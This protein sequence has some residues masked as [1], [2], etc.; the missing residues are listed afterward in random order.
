MGE[1]LMARNCTVCDSAGRDAID[2][3]LVAGRSMRSIAQRHG[4]GEYAVA[5]HRD[6]HLSAALVATVRN[7]EGRRARTLLSRVEGI[8]SEAESI[9][10]G[11]KDSGK[12]S[13]ALAAIREL[14]GLYE[15][16][17]RLTGELKPDNAVT[18]VN[19][20]QDPEWLAIRSRLLLALAPFPDARSAVVA[21]LAGEPVARPTERR[22]LPNSLAS[23]GEEAAP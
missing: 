20:Q 13:A 18:V 4:V 2:R 1:R 6:N 3:E 16:L 12:V 7:S 11:A 17:G 9:L 8:V 5:R 21:A 19:V 15:L 14:R 23:V 10:T 22:G